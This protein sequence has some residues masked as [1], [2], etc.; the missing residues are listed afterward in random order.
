MLPADAPAWA[1]DRAALWNQ[2]E[3]SET[4]KNAVVAREWE[5]ALPSELGGAARREVVQALAQALVDR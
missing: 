4:R 2:A 1:Q 3:A 5:V